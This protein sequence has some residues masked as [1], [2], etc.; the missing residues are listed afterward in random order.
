MSQS[1]LVEARINGRVFRLGAPAGEIETL[2]EAVAIVEAE[3]NVIAQ[4][5]PTVEIERVL[6]LAALGLAAGK[7]GGRAEDP[8]NEA[9]ILALTQKLKAALDSE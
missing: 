3:C 7:Q 1:N 2:T 5:Q 6:L 8:R 4:K 9:R